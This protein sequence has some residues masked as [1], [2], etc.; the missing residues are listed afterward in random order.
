[1]RKI[2]LFLLV[3]LTT[4]LPALAEDADE[5]LFP[6]RGGN[7][8]WGYINASAEWVIAPQFDGADDFRGNYAVAYTAPEALTAEEIAGYLSEHD[9]S[10]IIDRTGAWVVPPEY[11]IDPGYGSGWYGGY[12]GGIWLLTKYEVP[13]EGD[14]EE[15]AI[16]PYGFFDIPSGYFSGLRWGSIG[17]W[18]SEDSRLIPVYDED[19]CLYGYADRSTGELVIPCLYGGV[20]DPAQFH[21][22][23][24]AVAIEHED[25]SNI[26]GWPFL[27]SEQGNHI[28]LPDGIHADANARASEGLITI[29]DEQ[30]RYG[31][32]DL[33][34]RVVIT[35]Q[36]DAA[37][38]FSEGLACVRL[39]GGQ[40]LTDGEHGYIDRT[41]KVILR[42]YQ[43]PIWGFEDGYAQV[44]LDGRRVFIDREGHVSPGAY[45]SNGLAWVA[46]TDADSEFTWWDHLIDRDG[47]Q[48]GPRWILSD[49]VSRVFDEGRQPVRDRQGR[50]CY[51][52]DSG[53]VII[54]G[55]FTSAAPFRNGLGLVRI[56]SR[57]GYIDRDG[58]EVYFWQYDDPF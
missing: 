12:D 43:W 49:Y 17:H 18:C 23:V 33:T 37:E 31:F 27:I 56:G 46:E 24:A 50:C 42:G 40:R 28:P 16:A 3:L 36:F 13:I 8:K 26:A 15:Y 41:G 39:T 53:A 45:M 22:G 14:E 48:V 47:R 35:P 30:D 34:G 9:C 51:L 32:A 2:L 58:N 1:M 25:D 38:H 6:A 7:G 20:G 19:T 5:P 21:E 55:P 52:D 10:G 54:E 44:T 57:E 4:A 11:S 29:T